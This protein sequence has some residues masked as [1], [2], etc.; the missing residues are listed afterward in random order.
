[1]EPKYKIG[2]K[3]IVKPVKNQSQSARDSDIGHYAGQRGTVTNYYWI[4]PIEGKVFYTYTVQFG[5]DQKEI[6]L[7]EDE[8]EA[9]TVKARKR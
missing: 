9:D 2:Q 7:H 3:V 1:M 8:I 6:V 5:T 4:S